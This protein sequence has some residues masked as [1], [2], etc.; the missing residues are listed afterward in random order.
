M[1]S[2][3]P[4]KG[5]YVDYA[6]FNHAYANLASTSVQ[7]ATSTATPIKQ[8]PNN[9]PIDPQLLRL[10]VDPDAPGPKRAK[11]YSSSLSLSTGPSTGPSTGTSAGSVGSLSLTMHHS[12]SSQSYPFPSPSTPYNLANLSLS[13]PASSAPPSVTADLMSPIDHEDSMTPIEAPSPTDSPSLDGDEE[14]EPA[15][16][17]GSL[18]ASVPA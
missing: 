17:D 1:S 7:S 15:S 9:I 13:T 2:L 5:H 16:L 3:P 6:S 4:S 11:M 8:D 14:A 18:V 12:R 10:T